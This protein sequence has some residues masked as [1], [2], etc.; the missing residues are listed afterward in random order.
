MDDIFEVMKNKIDVILSSAR[1]EVFQGETRLKFNP[2]KC[3]LMVMN[4]VE[5]FNDDI[6]G[7]RILFTDEHE[8]LGTLVS[9]DGL[10]VAEINRRLKD[11]T[12]VSNEVVQ[13][14]KSCELS[15]CRLRYLKNLSNACIDS[16][17]KYGCGVWNKLL[18]VKLKVIKRLLE[19]SSSTP[20]SLVKYDFGIIDMDIE[21]TMEKIL[22]ASK[23]IKKGVLE[24]CCSLQCLKRMFLGFVLNKRI[25]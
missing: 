9:N 16:K 12:S 17:I 22:L 4:K 25:I 14:L 15:K 20:S 3:K 10:R 6:C 7:G 23:A 2:S 21:V 18:N 5:E 24:K 1:A 8:Y 19:L 13:V 11:S